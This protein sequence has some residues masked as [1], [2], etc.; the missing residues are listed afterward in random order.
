MKLIKANIEDAK[1]SYN[2]NRK[3]LEEFRNSGEACMEVVEYSQAHAK[4][5]ASS[6]TTSVRRF[7]MFNIQVV[8]KKGRVFLINTLLTKE[9]TAKKAES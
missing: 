7:K 1:R 6:L 3:M 5:C 2:H 8:M 4:S 9:L